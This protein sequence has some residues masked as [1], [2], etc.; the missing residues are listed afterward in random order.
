M[1]LANSN[2]VSYLVT[3]SAAGTFQGVPQNDPDASLG[4]QLSSTPLSNSDGNLYTAI[5]QAQK[6][7][8]TLYRCFGVLMTSAVDKLDIA[9]ILVDNM[10]SLPTGATLEYGLFTADRLD[11]PCPISVD[12]DTAAPGI[13]YFVPSEYTGDPNAD[14]SNG[15]PLG[16]LNADS[17]NATELTFDD[18]IVVFVYMKLI[19]LAVTD[20]LNTSDIFTPFIGDESVV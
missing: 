8:S 3:G 1:A 9:H 5:T 10:P 13:T 7:S 14:Y 19:L 16:P 6:T 15:R 12:E 2:F 17:D 18:S 11:T 4:G 20:S